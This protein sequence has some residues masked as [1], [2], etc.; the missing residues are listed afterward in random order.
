MQLLHCSDQINTAR[1]ITELVQGT[2]HDVQGT[3]HDQVTNH[4][5][6]EFELGHNESLINTTIGMNSK[7]N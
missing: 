3:A 7:Y 4:E 2:A 1:S 5:S 6:S